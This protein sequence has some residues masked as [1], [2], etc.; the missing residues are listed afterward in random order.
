MQTLVNAIAALVQALGWVAWVVVRR[1]LIVVAV[2]AATAFGGWM[3]VAVARWAD[4]RPLAPESE[5][6]GFLGRLL[7]REAEPVDLEA[8]WQAH[9]GDV[10]VNGA[11]VA[12]VSMLVVGLLA[13]FAVHRFQAALGWAAALSALLFVIAAQGGISGGNPLWPSFV[14]PLAAVPV[15]M[16]AWVLLDTIGHA[17]SVALDGPPSHGGGSGK[18]GAGGREACYG[19][20]GVGSGEFDFSIDP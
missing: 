12:F 10:F 2:L 6:P 11:M 3:A 19:D 4:K 7:G 14:A 5:E 18:P 9:L 17:L 16:G 8:L 1:V 13:S 15:G 20:D